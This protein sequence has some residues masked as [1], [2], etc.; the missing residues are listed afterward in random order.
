MPLPAQTTVL[1]N[2]A[3]KFQHIDI[4]FKP[5][6]EKATTVHSLLVTGFADVPQGIHKV[7]VFERKY[8]RI[9]HEEADVIIHHREQQLWE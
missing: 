7:V 2:T 4:I 8:L 9:S 5:H 3:N 6:T 1:T